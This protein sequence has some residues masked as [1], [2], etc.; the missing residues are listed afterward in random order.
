ML[1]VLVIGNVPGLRTRLAGFLAPTP[2]PTSA[3]SL[4]FIG[5][6]TSSVIIIS[7][8]Y[9]TPNTPQN[10]PGPLPTT[11]PQSSNLQYFTTPLDP[12]GL[13]AS[14]IW[15]SGFTGP[16]AVLND[17]VPLNPQA[18]HA[19]WPFGWYESLTVFIQKNYHGN[20]PARQ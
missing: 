8:R 4:V 11:C 17:L 19:S 5:Q 15:I 9:G 14:S 13:G 6:D 18:T 16:S 1:L 20:D 12:P 7:P 3:S 10:A 2:T